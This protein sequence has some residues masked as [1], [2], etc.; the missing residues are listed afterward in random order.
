M[1][2]AKARELEGTDSSFMYISREHSTFSQASAV[3]M[4]RYD[5][6]RNGEGKRE[7]E[8][9]QERQDIIEQER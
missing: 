3:S 2:D 6:D 9:R 8:E 4:S 5:N 1:H 7:G